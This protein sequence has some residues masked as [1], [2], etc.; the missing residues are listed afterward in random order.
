MSLRLHLVTHNVW[1]IPFGGPWFLGRAK[2]CIEN[3]GYA[4]DALCE[5]SKSKSSEQS[6][7]LEITVIVAQ[8]F[9]ALR[10]G[11]FWPLLWGLA[12]FESFLLQQGYANGSHEYR[13][14]WLLKSLILLV[15]AVI[16]LLIQTWIPILRWVL[17]DPKDDAATAFRQQ[18][19]LGWTISGASKFRHTPPWELSPPVLMDSGLMLSSSIPPDNHGFVPYSKK[20]NHE[21]IAMKGVLWARYGYVGIVTTHM[22]FF[23]KDV[24]QERGSQQRQ[25]LAVLASL[26][27]LSGAKSIEQP[28]DQIIL[29]GDFNHCLEEQTTSLDPGPGPGEGSP[30]VF[31]RPWLPTHASVG[32]LIEVLEMDGNLKVRRLSGLQPTCEDGT[33]DHIFQ[34]TRQHGG[35]L[36]C[37]VEAMVVTSDDKC[38]YSDHCMISST[39][40]LKGLSNT[41]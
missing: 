29:A 31:R 25:L 38:R 16:S 37:S 39:L 12:K 30:S 15:V 41:L 28:V 22:T 23:N 3:L 34:I 8:E 27:G 7:T 14:Y 13:I 10:V 9:W 5:A 2:R 19:G 11:I 17:W 24:G 6:E 33:V 18:F 40:L 20:G 36:D 26:L 35:A 32:K 1:L 4:V 21:A